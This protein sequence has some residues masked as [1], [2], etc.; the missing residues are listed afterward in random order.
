MTDLEILETL[1][2]FVYGGATLT[3][4]Q[5]AECLAY[6]NRAIDRLDDPE[7]LNR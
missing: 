1:R 4:Q 7:Y 6:L 5:A 2:R 3:E